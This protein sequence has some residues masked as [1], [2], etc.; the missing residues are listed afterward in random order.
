[1]IVRAYAALCGQSLSQVLRHYDIATNQVCFEYPPNNTPVC[2]QRTE[3]LFQMSTSTSTP[4]SVIIG[5]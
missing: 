5:K 2:D 1:M 3:L 4:P